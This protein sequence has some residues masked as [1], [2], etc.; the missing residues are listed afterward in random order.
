[1]TNSGIPVSVINSD[2]DEIFPTD[3]VIQSPKLFA[4]PLN[5]PAIVNT[6]GESD[7]PLLRFT[8]IRFTKLNSTSIGACYAHTLCAFLLDPKFLP[9][10]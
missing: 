1:L 6:E 3:L 10:C 8:I 7:E 9:V 2:A 5:V 4:K